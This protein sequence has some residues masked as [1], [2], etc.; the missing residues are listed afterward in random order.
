MDEDEKRMNVKLEY[1][2]LMSCKNWNA[3]SILNPS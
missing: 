1:I 3:W 2:E